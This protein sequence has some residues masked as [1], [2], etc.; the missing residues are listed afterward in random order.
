ML[1]ATLPRLHGSKGSGWEL[2]AFTGDLKSGNEVKHLYLLLLTWANR[3]ARYWKYL[4]S[5]SQCSISSP[6]FAGVGGNFTEAE[7]KFTP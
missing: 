5:L 7:A 3:Q 4:G 6:R 1:K 2:G